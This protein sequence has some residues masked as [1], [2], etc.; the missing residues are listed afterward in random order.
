MALIPTTGP[1]HHTRLPLGGC[2]PCRPLKAGRHGGFSL[3]ELLVVVAIIAVLVSILFP[4]VTSARNTARAVSSRSLLNSI[5]QASQQ[6]ELDNGRKP[7]FYSPAEMGSVQNG[8]APGSVT[9]ANGGTGAGMTAMENIILDLAGRDAIIDENEQ[10]FDQTFMARV[11]PFLSPTDPGAIVVN[12]DLVGA[13]EG[14][15]IAIS[16]RFFA[17]QPAEPT[18]PQT[19]TNAQ[20]T[21]VQNLGNA[22][23]AGQPQLPDVIDA[24][25][26]PVL[27][28][29]ADR[30]AVPSISAPGD[31]APPSN[32]AALA[33]DAATNAGPALFYWNANAGYLRANAL[34]QRR[35]DQTKDPTTLGET[36]LLGVGSIGHINGYSG[37]SGV[38]H[39]FAAV[40]GAPG[41]PDQSS[42]VPGGGDS[43]V[44]TAYPTR[45][46]GDFILQSAGQDGYYLSTNSS[47]MRGITEQGVQAWDAA[48]DGGP[49]FRY[50][51]NFRA[52]GAI[53][54]ND[55]IPAQDIIEP[56]DDIL[57]SD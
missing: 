54:P 13:D 57:V 4:V 12:P 39:V 2:R 51:L 48:G 11:G 16:D 9:A 44:D 24:F 52:L 6:F 55:P 15:Y 27:A 29:V 23:P 1:T 45:P 7:G 18:N 28:W 3:V 42:L 36:S 35:R 14:A 46:R 41:S 8:G 25:G 56:F 32:F 53:D 38:N 33:S 22:A 10:P 19:G 40:L 26:Q 31:T 37:P 49:V 20:W 34:G 47:A 21:T 30:S 50:G 17:P 43:L 5:L